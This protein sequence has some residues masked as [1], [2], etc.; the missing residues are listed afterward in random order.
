MNATCHMVIRRGAHLPSQPPHTLPSQR[1]VSS[2][3][4]WL[5]CPFFFNSSVWESEHNL[6]LESYGVCLAWNKLRR[7]RM[8][9]T[10][11]SSKFHTNPTTLNFELFF[12]HLVIPP[13]WKLFRPQKITFSCPVGEGTIPLH[14]QSQSIWPL[15]DLFPWVPLKGNPHSLI[16]KTLFFCQV[17]CLIVAHQG[18]SEKNSL[19]K[20][21]GHFL[22]DLQST[23]AHTTLS[24]WH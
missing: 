17:W 3:D 9:S 2:T 1:H 21:F 8:M 15:K 20:E 23:E 22:L 5:G 13:H 18:I 12:Q 7:F 11:Q 16:L 14:F 6:F 10:T 24:S 4:Y 19:W